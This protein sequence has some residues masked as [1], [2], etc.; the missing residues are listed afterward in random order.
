MSTEKA[1]LINSE[2]AGLMDIYSGSL[3]AYADYAVSSGKKDFIL[4]TQFLGKTLAKSSRL[5]ELLDHYNAK[6]NKLW[7]PYRQFTA[8]VKLFV[9]IAYITL[10]LKSTSP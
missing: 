10:H 2:F 1:K 4:T 7:N 5:E 6:N 3:L 9:N 8:S